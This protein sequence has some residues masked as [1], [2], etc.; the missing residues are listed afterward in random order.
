[1]GRDFTI[2]SKAEGVVAFR[3]ST[4]FHRGKNFVDVTTENEIQIQKEFDKKASEPKKT[5]ANSSKASKK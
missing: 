5:S 1:M 3:K 2:F 4:G